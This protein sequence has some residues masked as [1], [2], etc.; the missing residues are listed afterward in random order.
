MGPGVARNQEWLR[1]RWPAGIYWAS[2]SNHNRVQFLTLYLLHFPTIYPVSV[3]EKG[4]WALSIPT[5]PTPLKNVVFVTKS[6]LPLSLLSY[7]FFHAAMGLGKA[8]LLS[9][10]P[11]CINFSYAFPKKRN[12]YVMKCGVHEAEE[13]LFLVNFFYRNLPA[14]TF[15]NV[16]KL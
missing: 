13:S 6:P 12:L 8:A 9:S 5:P 4:E 11:I 14:N 3:Y 1:W 15:L 10:Q 7:A 16:N 2:I